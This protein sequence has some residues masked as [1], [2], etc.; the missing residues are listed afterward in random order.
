MNTIA[1]E[2]ENEFDSGEIRILT[3]L[4]E[5]PNGISFR[6]LY[7]LAFKDKRFSIRSVHKRV[8]SL[9][10][11][12]FISEE[13]ENWRRGREKTLK[14]TKK[15]YETT[16]LLFTLDILKESA[17]KFIEYI[18]KY[19]CEKRNPHELQFG[20]WFARA[21]LALF[22]IMIENHMRDMVS[23]R[24]FNK[25]GMND[26]F[27]NVWD[28][29]RKEIFTAYKK[30]EKL[31]LENYLKQFNLNEEGLNETEKITEYISM[32]NTMIEFINNLVIFYSLWELLSSK[33]VFYVSSNSIPS[34]LTPTPKMWEIVSKVFNDLRIKFDRFIEE[35]IKEREKR[36]KELL[37][38]E[39]RV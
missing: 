37:Y 9:I 7:D 38:G 26:L 30:L 8:R 39:T 21:K 20:N 25:D 6:K 31:E 36:F 10:E 1:Y 35:T 22:E 15:G 5:F 16:N 24:L 14:L 12:G 28:D 34:S 3:T 4:F 19:D 17:K 23:E 32:A 29:I 2:N 18:L 27:F 11:R 33:F 13:I